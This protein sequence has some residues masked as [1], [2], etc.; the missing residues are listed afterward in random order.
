MDAATMPLVGAVTFPSSQYVIW[1]VRAVLPVIFFILWFRLQYPKGAWWPESNANKH[2]KETLLAMRKVVEEEPVPSSMLTLRLVSEAANP[3]L[4]GGSRPTRSSP[5]APAGGR[6]KKGPRDKKRPGDKGQGEGFDGEEALYISEEER[7]HLESLVN[8][9]AFSR[10]E[11]KRVFLPDATCTP[12]PPPLP[13]QPPTEPIEAGSPEAVKANAEAQMVLRGVLSKQLQAKRA[14]V[15]KDLHKNLADSYVEISEATFS[16]MVEVCIAA[17]DLKGASD[18]LLRMESAEHCPDSD[19]LD[20]VM[21][22]YSK[23][24]NPGEPQATDNPLGQEKIDA[25]G[26]PVGGG[27][28]MFD[29][30]APLSQPSCMKPRDREKLSQKSSRPGGQGGGSNAALNFGAYFDDDD[31]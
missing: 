18:F 25:L 13:P 17:E 12:P 16:L 28:P 21:D 15:A 10:K 31:D 14:D 30:D 9:I 6:E 5:K 3:A 20:K 24:K 29:F 1:I 26:D 2:T 19:L 11:Q 27:G 8:Y 7:M 23:Q 22:L 4:F